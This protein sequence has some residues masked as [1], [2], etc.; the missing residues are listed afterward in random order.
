MNFLS[1]ELK[2]VVTAGASGIGKTIAQAYK[3]EGCRVHICDISDESISSFKSEESDIFVQ[4][5][6]VSVYSEVKSFFTNV[7][8]QVNS[9]DVLI[10]GEIR[11]MST[12]DLIR[13][14]DV[15]KKSDE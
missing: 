1:Q 2:V 14:K 9:V 4:K 12:R 13:L 3:N 7:A 6:D 15:K 10:N 5:T 11:H 8:Q